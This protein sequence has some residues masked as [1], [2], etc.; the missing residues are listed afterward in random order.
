MQ[1]KYETFSFIGFYYN[2]DGISL[3]LDPF[4]GTAFTM[5]S[6]SFSFP[7]QMKLHKFRKTYSGV[8]FLQ[9]WKG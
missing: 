4:L 5:G 7:K 2:L 9:I 8:E 6:L 1:M 3:Y